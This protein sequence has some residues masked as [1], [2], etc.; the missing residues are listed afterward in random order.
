MQSDDVVLDICCG[1]G[2]FTGKLAPLC[3]RILGVDFSEPLIN[4]AR[5]Y[6]Q[7]ENAEYLLGDVR[8]LDGLKLDHIEQFNKV[9]MIG[10]LQYF[11]IREFEAIIDDLFIRLPLGVRM[12]FLG[13]VLDRETKWTMLNSP[14]KK[15][16]YAYYVLVGRN[17]LGRFWRRSEI[18]EL[19]QIRQ[20]NH[21]FCVGDLACD[22]PVAK[23]RFDATITRISHR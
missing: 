4:I 8:R 3:A 23:F 17:S 16:M 9:I 13:S 6:N 10:A 14:K 20:L 11:S 22:I 19:T 7:P 18:K 1:N 15:L 12:L 21:K 2:L 5:R